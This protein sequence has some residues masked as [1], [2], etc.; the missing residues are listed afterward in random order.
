MDIHS[1][2]LL[3][4]STNQSSIMLCT[5]KPQLFLLQPNA[6]FILTAV[7]KI[8]E[9][10]LHLMH[11]LQ[12]CNITLKSA[13]PLSGVHWE[14]T[15]H[16]AVSSVD[17]CC[18]WP[19]YWRYILGGPLYGTGKYSSIESSSSYTGIQKFSSCVNNIWPY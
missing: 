16:Q 12:C 7:V 18:W 13:I 14:P 17:L 3:G 19:A 4:L 1:P 6:V 8:V 5:L 2:N 15:L 10:Q 11:H 9:R